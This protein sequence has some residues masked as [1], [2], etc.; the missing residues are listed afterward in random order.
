MGAPFCRL[1]DPLALSPGVASCI[2]LKPT[3]IAIDSGAQIF[4]DKIDDALVKRRGMLLSNE[5]TS[6]YFKFP[7]PG[8]I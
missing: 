1:E 5:I 8:V 3:S 7:L 2:V 4:I 6:R